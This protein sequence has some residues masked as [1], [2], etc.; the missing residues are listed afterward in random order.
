VQFTEN[1][2]LGLRASVLTLSH[3][4]HPTQFMLCPVVRIGERAY[5]EAVKAQIAGCDA[6]IHEGVRSFARRKRLGYVLLRLLTP[7]DLRLGGSLLAQGGAL[8]NYGARY[9]GV[10]LLTPAAFG[11]AGA[12][13][14]YLVGRYLVIR[15]A[16]SCEVLGGR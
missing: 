4:S 13:V 1:S 10:T 9:L 12:M 8:T 7:N 3:P 16:A 2:A 14:F 5:Y 15:G 11:A 6:L